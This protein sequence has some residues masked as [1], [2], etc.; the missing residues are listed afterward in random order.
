MEL[1][2]ATLGREDALGDVLSV[3]H[4]LLHLGSTEF[5][6]VAS[7][8]LFSAL[9]LSGTETVHTV[10]LSHLR[11]CLE[12]IKVAAPSL[13]RAKSPCVLSI[14]YHALITHTVGVRS[15]HVG[16]VNHARL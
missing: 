8:G 3:I 5:A 4:H 1:F 10:V 15:I 6:D 16:T 7:V 13:V 2:R 11:V 9:F 12:A 14:A